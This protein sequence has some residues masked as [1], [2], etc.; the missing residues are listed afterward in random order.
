LV[1]SE[2]SLKIK[3]QSAFCCLPTV[4]EMDLGIT[5]KQQTNRRRINRAYRT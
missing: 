2:Q 4:Y 5:N 3:F 1:F